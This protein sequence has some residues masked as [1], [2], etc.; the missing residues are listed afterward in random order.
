MEKPA[1]MQE[2][3]VTVEPEP[4][5]APAVVILPKKQALSRANRKTK[6]DDAERRNLIAEI[7][8]I[9]RRNLSGPGG[10][11]T[12]TREQKIKA[13]NKKY[14][15]T[16]HTNLLHLSVDKLRVSLETLNAPDSRGRLHNERSG[17]RERSHGQSEI[18]RILNAKQ[19]DSGYFEDEDQDPSM[20][21]GFRV[22]PVGTAPDS[23]ETEDESTDSADKIS[24]DSAKPEPN[25]STDDKWRDQ[26]VESLVRKMFLASNPARCPVCDETFPS[27]IGAENHLTEQY[28]KGEK[29]LSKFFEYSWALQQMRLNGSMPPGLQ[30]DSK[31][32]GLP[33][34][35]H[36]HILDEMQLVQKQSRKKWA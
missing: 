18:E 33:Y 4:A 13:A 1:P 28:V 6:Q 30:E 32:R 9:A 14:I 7:L 16:L 10:D 31:P 27:Q 12:G 5:P 35:H 29:D 8:V 21:A 17:E 36:V 26:A 19:H 20:A 3:A 25:Q 34:L 11:I 22:N 2:I 15:R 24:P 23:F